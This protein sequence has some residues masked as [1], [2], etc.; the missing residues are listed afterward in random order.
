MPNPLKPGDPIR[1]LMDQGFDQIYGDG[2]DNKAESSPYV[3]K[4]RTDVFTMTGPVGVVANLTGSGAFPD[5]AADTI[6]KA[7]TITVTNRGSEPLDIGKVDVA[8]TDGVSHA[9]FLIAGDTCDNSTVGIGQSCTVDVRFAP[10]DS[11][12][13]SAA[14]LVVNSNV[15]SGNTTMNLTGTSTDLP[16]GAAGA[17]GSTGPAGPAGPQG[18]TGAQGGSGPQGP[19]GSQGGTGPQGR[20]GFAG[21]G[22]S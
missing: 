12:A 19:A 9:N 1:L 18:G 4:G 21:P 15:P 16:S 6:G 17:A 5:Q 2:L 20:Y 22:W 14:Q 3:S 11:N 7:K 13:T 8:D 10:Q